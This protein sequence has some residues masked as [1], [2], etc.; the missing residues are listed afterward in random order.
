MSLLVRKKLIEVNYE[1][2]KLYMLNISCVLYFLKIEV[3]H[4][5]FLLRRRYWNFNATTH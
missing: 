4:Y 2:Y 5:F 1:S 3:I